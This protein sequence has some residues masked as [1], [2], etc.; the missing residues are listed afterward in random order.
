MIHFGVQPHIVHTDDHEG[1][2]TGT[3]QWSSS[4]NASTARQEITADLLQMNRE[5]IRDSE[6]TRVIQ[7]R[8]VK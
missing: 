7:M 8:R 1:V 4:D 5:R 3:Y 2:K 6:K